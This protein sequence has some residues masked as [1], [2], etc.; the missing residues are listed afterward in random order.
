M[1]K[2]LKDRTKFSILT[3]LRTAIASTNAVNLINQGKI[4]LKK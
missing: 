3:L 2:L 1:Q 4:W